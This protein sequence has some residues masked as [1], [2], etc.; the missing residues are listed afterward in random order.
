VYLKKV[1]IT[2]IEENGKIPKQF[3]EI[4]GRIKQGLK[5]QNQYDCK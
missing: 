4:S 5:P 1:I 3:F 2:E